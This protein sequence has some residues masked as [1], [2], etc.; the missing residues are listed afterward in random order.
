ML[1]AQDQRAGAAYA[2]DVHKDLNSDHKIVK[3]GGMYLPS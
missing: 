2:R 3:C 1:T